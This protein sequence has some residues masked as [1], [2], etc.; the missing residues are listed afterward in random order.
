MSLGSSRQIFLFAATAF[1]VIFALLASSSGHAQDISFDRE[2]FDFSYTPSES[3][4]RAFQGE[5]QIG[6]LGRSVIA[7]SRSYF[8]DVEA[9]GSYSGMTISQTLGITP[10][11]KAAGLG[12]YFLSV[13]YGAQIFSKG[14]GGPVSGP[15]NPIMGYVMRF[16]TII[17]IA[18][19]GVLAMAHLVTMFFSYSEYG[20]IFGESRDRF[21]G[22]V[23]AVATLLLI[24][25]IA[26]GGLSAAQY[27]GI[28]A[29]ATSNGMGN[30]LAF[31][32][33]GRGFGDPVTG[34][35][36]FNVQGSASM[37]P[38]IASETFGQMVGATSCRN[39]L[40]AMGQ[41]EA[42]IS[43]QCGRI[44]VTSQD[45]DTALTTDPD[46]DAMATSQATASC[47][48]IGGA[49]GVIEACGAIR[50][51]QQD[52]QADIDAIAEA[53]GGDLTTPEARQAI[54]DVAEVYAQR[55][56]D[57][58]QDM[59]SVI[60]EDSNANC[61][62][63]AS[64]M[65]S[66]EGS[67]DYGYDNLVSPTVIG[68]EFQSTILQLGWPG[69][70][71]IYSSLGERVDAVNAMQRN[72]SDSGGFSISNMQ[73]INQHQ[74]R[75]TRTVTRNSAA[76]QAA[77]QAA[78]QNEDIGRDGDGGFLWHGTL[79]NIFSDWIGQGANA[80]DDLTMTLNEQ[81][82]RPI[83]W[84]LD[85]IFSKPATQGMYEVGA[86]TLAIVAI[87]AGLSDMASLLKGVVGV[88]S[89]AGFAAV[90]GFE[91]FKMT[92]SEIIDSS[93]ILSALMAAIGLLVMLLLFTAA[94]LVVVLPK[95]PLLIIALL[96]AEW[97]IWCAIIA[98]GSSIWVAVN[99]SA[100]TNTPHLLTMAF[101]RGIGV[102]MYIL[103][104]PTLVVIAI[105]ISVVI[106]NLAVP[107]VA[108]LML[109]AFGTGMVDSLIGIFAMPFM[110]IFSAT[111]MAFMAVTSIAR[112]PDMIN[113][114]LGIQ[115]PGQSISQ[116]MNSYMGN[117]NQ[118]N[119]AADPGNVLKSLGGR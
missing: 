80:V 84:W 103:I 93:V 91:L 89:P 35:S 37:D 50:K 3:A 4:S 22:G 64:S 59:N 111:I 97:A 41:T 16:A 61:N 104:Y 29:A 77:I 51:Q 17:G 56:N 62:N 58:V 18:V 24:S 109:T 28:T 106:Y 34:G 114:M 53:H 10:E 21:I 86:R 2:N 87:V 92:V 13:V 39:L 68:Q 38:N 85:P 8:P 95:I 108:I 79:S 75:V 113:G 116:S 36:I 98:W 54:A 26:E 20:D 73:G 88:T 12:G 60:C 57:Y 71:T 115:S 74:V 27:G 30:R 33:A 78:A 66:N 15:E 96:L 110:V 44:N 1:L 83:R 42:E 70:A 14:V 99:L 23:R 55:I 94:F 72:G 102:L 101:L 25:P 63:V 5:S 45:A 76:G 47:A 69:L 105:V 82:Q 67:A 81:A 90:A 43:S 118:F 112:I 49:S 119:P 117:P 19:A 107:T 40:G 31:V 6:E 11:Y 52:A 65:A 7:S 32:V 100:I 46:E 48:D 9:A